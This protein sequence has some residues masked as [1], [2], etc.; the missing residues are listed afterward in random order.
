MYLNLDG[1][2]VPG[3]NGRMSCNTDVKFATIFSCIFCACHV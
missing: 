2:K 3:G 1:L